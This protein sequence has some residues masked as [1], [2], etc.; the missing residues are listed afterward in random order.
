MKIKVKYFE[1]G[2]KLVFAK[3]KDFNKGG[4]LV[5]RIVNKGGRSLPF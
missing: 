5:E 4:K 1:D 2:E 3:I